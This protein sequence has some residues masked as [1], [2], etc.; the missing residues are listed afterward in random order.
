MTDFFIPIAGTISVGAKTHR[1]H[2]GVHPLPD[3]VA[4]SHEANAYGIKTT[5][6][7]TDDDWLSCGL[8]K[9]AAPKPQAAPVKLA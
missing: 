5:D 7:M 9:P 4:N 6:E 2:R 1:M 3:W 8:V